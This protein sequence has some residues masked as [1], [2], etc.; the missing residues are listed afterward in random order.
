MEILKF[1][2]T[3]PL[4]EL[5]QSTLKKIGFYNGSIDGIFGNET[6]NS[7]VLFQQ[8]FGLASDG[9]VGVNTWNALFPYIYGFTTYSVS[10][11]DTLYSISSYF[12]TSVNRILMANPGIVADS[13]YVGQKIIVPFGNV[14]PTD[15][16]Y[17]YNILEMNV[18]SLKMIYPFLEVGY[19]GKSVLGKDIPYI[20][21]GKGSKEVFY[22][23]SFHANEWITSSLVMKFVEDFSRAFVDNSSVFGYNAD[24]IFNSCSIYIVPMVNP[25]GVDLVTGAIASGTSVYNSAKRISDDYPDIAFP[26]GWKA[27]I[28]GVD[29][30]IYQPV[31]KVL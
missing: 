28:R 8:R 25:D 11:G 15:V 19:I 30:K 3:G 14:V 9:I 17:C 13:L 29:L 27:N 23:S 6:R 21:I 20:R 5:L 26:S 10:A 12:S 1:G 4:V 31:C 7:V 2:S 24:F 16:S 18:Y 22:N